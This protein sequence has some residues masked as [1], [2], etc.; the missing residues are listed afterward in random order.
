MPFLPRR[1]PAVVAVSAAVALVVLLVLAVVPWSALRHL[2]AA[3]PADGHALLV[4]E[5]GARTAVRAVTDLGGSLVVDVVA[6]VAAGVLLLLRRWRAAVVVVVARLGELATVTLLK[7]AVDRMRPHLL[8][9]LVQAEGA[10]FPSGHTAGSAAVYGVVAVVLGAWLGRAAR[11]WLFVAV[12]L[13]VAAVAAS[14]VLVGVHFP[15]DV[16]GGAAL[17][18]LWVAVAL[19]VVPAERAPD[20]VAADDVSAR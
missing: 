6:A 20:P 11:R 14:R 19:L 1:R 17:G 5:T 12:G 4:S 7:V 2:D 15:T 18:V 13:I 3:G 9:H 16:L 10:S 8:P